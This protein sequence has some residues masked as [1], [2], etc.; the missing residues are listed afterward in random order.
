M[1]TKRTRRRRGRHAPRAAS[2]GPSARRCSRPLLDARAAAQPLAAGGGRGGADRRSLALPAFG[3]VVLKMLPFDNKSEFQVLLDMPGA[4][5][6][7]ADAAVLRELADAL[8][9]DVPEVPT[10]RPTPAR[11]R[12][13]ISTAWCASTTCAPAA[14]GDLQVNLVDKHERKRRATP[15]PRAVRPALQRSARATAPT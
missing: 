13:S 1:A 3:L 2:T 14:M 10:T 7:S 12:R 6:W 15:S 8:V 5:R 4:R 11:R 9:R